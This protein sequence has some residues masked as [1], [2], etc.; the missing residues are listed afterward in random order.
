M[1][2]PRILDFREDVT[3]VLE[4]VY[5][6]GTT[7]FMAEVPL[8]SCRCHLLGAFDQA[9]P[10]V[11]TVRGIENATFDRASASPL[12]QFYDMYQPETLAE[13]LGLTEDEATEELKRSPVGA[14]APAP[15][16]AGPVLKRSGKKRSSSKRQ[17]SRLRSTD[18]SLYY[19]PA[20][21]TFIQKQIDKLTALQ[22][23]AAVNGSEPGAD[24]D[25][26][27]GSLLLTEQSH[28]IWISK[29]HLALAVLAAAGY[30]TVPV[31]FGDKHHPHVI[32]REDAPFWA[33]VQR[34]IFTQVQARRIFDQVLGARMSDPGEAYIH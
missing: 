3:N 30:E 24:F 18:G 6:A 21:E 4:G 33:L 8:V 17:S 23:H 34:K 16:D 11:E 31:V 22:T 15:W 25:F 1:A 2:K 26:I 14:L 20:G 10:L 28:S 7:M 19:G 13:A 29:G 32:R 27:H 5:L 9:N 12:G